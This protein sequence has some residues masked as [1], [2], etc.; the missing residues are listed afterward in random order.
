[1]YL[2]SSGEVM[3]S[4]QQQE[5]RTVVANLREGNF[6]CSLA[7]SAREPIS[8]SVEVR[9]EARLMVLPREVLLAQLQEHHSI[10]EAL[11]RLVSY[12]QIVVGKTNYSRIGVPG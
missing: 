10:R 12:R 8:A 9:D 1:M 5:R 2:I 6:F 4:H 11:G 7:Q 3:V